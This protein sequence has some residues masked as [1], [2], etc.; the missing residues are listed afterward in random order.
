MEQNSDS[1]TSNINNTNSNEYLI[2]IIHY[3]CTS[4]T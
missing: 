4:S 3:K 2:N 1:K